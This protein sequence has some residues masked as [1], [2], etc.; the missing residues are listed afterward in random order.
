MNNDEK[1]QICAAIVEN[2]GHA[3]ARAGSAVWHRMR[4]PIMHPV[5]DDDDAILFAA[6]VK[7]ECWKRGIG[8]EV[9]AAHSV[10]RGEVGVGPLSSAFW[11]GGAQK[12][13]PS[14]PVAEAWAVLQAYAR[15]LTT[16]EGQDND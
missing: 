14:D 10:G 13:D 9:C 2:L 1:R 6:Q 7:A 15:A 11:S 3:T 5:R 8:Y 4:G 12:Y 16:K